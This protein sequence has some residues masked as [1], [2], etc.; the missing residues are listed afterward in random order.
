L[1][2]EL[3]EEMGQM[4][5]VIHILDD[6]YLSDLLPYVGTGSIIVEHPL[7]RIDENT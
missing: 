2:E 6:H 7:S 1:K 3:S 4:D 5:R